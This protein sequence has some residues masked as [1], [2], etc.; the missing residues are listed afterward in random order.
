[1]RLRLSLLTRNLSKRR[2]NV[3]LLPLLL[4]FA[5]LVMA[6]PATEETVHQLSEFVAVTAM[7]ISF[8][9]GAILGHQR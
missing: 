6:D 8:C 3:K 9:L 7:V 2:H 4:M 1:M 5:P